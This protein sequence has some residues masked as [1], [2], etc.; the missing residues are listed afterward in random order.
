MQIENGMDMTFKNTMNTG[1]IQTRTTA[2][3]LRLATDTQFSH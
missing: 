2:L 1:Y 3:E